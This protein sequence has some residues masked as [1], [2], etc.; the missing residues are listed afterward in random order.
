LQE[1]LPPFAED[2]KRAPDTGTYERASAAYVT[3]AYAEAE[4]L[5]LAAADEAQRATPPKLG[6]AIKAFELA[7]NSADR[8]FDYAEALQHYR[9]AAKLTDRTRD[10]G[11]WCGQQWHI[12]FVLD[13]QGQYGESE[14]MYRAVLDELKRVYGDRANNQVSVLDIRNNLGSAL[15]SQ[16][17]YSAAETAFREVLKLKEKV[18]GPQDPSTLISRLNLANALDDQAKYDQAKREYMEVLRLSEKIL[19]PEDPST[20]STRQELAISIQRQGKYDEAEK[21]YREVFRLREKVLGPEHPDTLRTREYLATSIFDQGEYG[22][23]E[24]EYREVLEVEEK[25]LGPEHPDSAESL[26]DLAEVAYSMRNFPRAEKLLR[27]ALD[28]REKLQGLKHPDLARPQSLLAASMAGHGDVSQAEVNIHRALTL[29]EQSRGSRHPYWAQQRLLMGVLQIRSAYD[30]AGGY[31]MLQQVQYVLRDLG[32]ERHPLYCQSIFEQ[33]DGIRSE[34]SDG[35]DEKESA[36]NIVAR[37]RMEEAIA[38][39]KNCIHSARPHRLERSIQ[40]LAI[41]R[42]ERLDLHAEL[43]SGLL[44]FFEL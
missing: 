1:K 25:V 26:E 28:I 8:R 31:R 34:V 23:A 37:R 27:Q 42:I 38:A 15:E 33:A 14:K 29:T 10:S 18:L 43:P 9:N 6:D 7:G 30:C 20:L 4:R 39:Y 2:L 32:L 11:E 19:G 5:A 41:A 16:G 44:H 12:A 17:K 21:E 13:E 35:L 40:L 24:K 3:K 36:L 22:E